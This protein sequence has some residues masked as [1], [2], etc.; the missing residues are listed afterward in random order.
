MKQYS[1]LPRALEL[2]PHLRMQFSV[3]PRI[4][5]FVCVCVCGGSYSFVVGVFYIPP[6]RQMLCFAFNIEISWVCMYVIWSKTHSIKNK[7]STGQLCM[8]NRKWAIIIASQNSIWCHAANI[9]TG[10]T[11]I[12]KTMFMYLFVISL[13][14]FKFEQRASIK[15]VC[16]TWKVGTRNVK[17]CQW[18]WNKIFFMAPTLQKL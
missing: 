13:M 9:S 10:V 17:I 4:T 8:N 12:F 18:P 2:K 15:Y 1:T 3:I 14:N 5:L 16:H 6:K 11:L 7:L